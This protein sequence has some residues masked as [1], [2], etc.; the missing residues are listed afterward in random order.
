M[1]SYRSK[2]SFDDDF[3]KKLT[4]RPTTASGSA[5]S[6]VIKSPLDKVYL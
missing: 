6:N 1:S 3:E 4:T 2:F 5:R